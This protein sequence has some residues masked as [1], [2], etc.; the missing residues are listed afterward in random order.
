[1]SRETLGD[2]SRF[3][4]RVW[5]AEDQDH[6]AQRDGGC[7]PCHAAR[8]MPG[9]PR[10]SFPADRCTLRGPVSG[11]TD[12][13]AVL[14]CIRVDTR[15]PKLTHV[16]DLLVTHAPSSYGAAPPATQRHR[17]DATTSTNA[18]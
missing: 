10:S 17:T 15:G 1:W 8:D 11:A 12:S 5:S 4:G 18:V 16:P 13:G 9:A 3:V 14:E 2:R 6:G 7:Y